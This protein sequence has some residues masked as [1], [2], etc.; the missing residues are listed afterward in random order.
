MVSIHV[1]LKRL[2]PCGYWQKREWLEITYLLPKICS[3]ENCPRIWT[4]YAWKSTNS[5]CLRTMV[6]T[7]P[8]PCAGRSVLPD[9]GTCL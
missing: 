5:I 8:E 6:V 2:S 1:Y 3:Q 7:E 4:D 9:S